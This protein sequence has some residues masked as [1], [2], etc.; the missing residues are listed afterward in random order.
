MRAAYALCV[1]NADN[2]YVKDG[3]RCCYTRGT[4]TNGTIGCIFGQILDHDEFD[5]A[6]QNNITISDVLEGSNFP[7]IM[8][9][10][11]ATLQVQQDIGKTW[12]DALLMAEQF[13][14]EQLDRLL[15][16]NP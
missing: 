5:L 15:M 10:W 16:D 1:N 4:C 7:D 13:Y 6:R 12:G 3:L 9:D 2:K 11:C 14:G 8:I